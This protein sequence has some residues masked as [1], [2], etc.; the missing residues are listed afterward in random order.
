MIVKNEHEKHYGYTP[1][2]ERKG[3]HQ[4]LL[5]DFGILRLRAGERWSDSSDTE[6]ALLLIEGEV[7]FEWEGKSFHAT[8]N[9]CFDETPIVLHLPRSVKASVTAKKESEIALEMCENPQAFEPKLYDK[10]DTRSDIFGGGTLNE[11]S[12]RTVRTVFDG[13]IAPYSNM[14]MGE[15]INHPG[16]WSSYPPHD[17]PQPEIYYY[18]FFPKQGFGVSLLEDD[19]FIVKDG[20]TSL[21]HP[22]KT[23]SQV[24]APGYAMYYIWMIPHLPNDRWLPTTRYYRQEHQWLLEKDVKIWPERKKTEDKA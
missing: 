14:V 1:I 9:S 12:I 5:L 4:E 15:V 3:K 17:H 18:H 6:R 21:I 10:G 20:D 8:R 2:T 16:K 13:E 23:H 11:T 7:V 19:A 24:A 22:D